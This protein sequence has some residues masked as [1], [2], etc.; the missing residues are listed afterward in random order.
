MKISWLVF[1]FI[2]AV[3]IEKSESG[4]G[5]FIFESL[6]SYSSFIDSLES[7]LVESISSG[8]SGLQSSGS[9]SSKS[10]DSSSDSSGS[11]SKPRDSSSSS[12]PR[13][14][15][16]VRSPN[17]SL[18][19][20][21]SSKSSSKPPS[22]SDKSKP[23]GSI[24]YRPSSTGQSRSLPK[25]GSISSRPSKSSSSWRSSRF[26]GS[27]TGSKP[28]GS[29][30][31][32]PASS[33]SSTDPCNQPLT[34]PNYGPRKGKLAN[35]VVQFQKSYSD[36]SNIK[37]SVNDALREKIGQAIDAIDSSDGASSLYGTKAF[38]QHLLNAKS[39][40]EH[41]EF[42]TG[43]SNINCK[44][45]V[46]KFHLVS[47]IGEL[48]AIESEDYNATV[49]VLESERSQIA[50]KNLGLDD[51]VAVLGAVI[52]TERKIYDEAELVIENIEN[53]LIGLETFKEEKCD[54]KSTTT[55]RPRK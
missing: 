33:S 54:T 20:K 14:S 47:H 51:V 46:E 55:G 21:P 26:S 42:G 43:P 49:R 9:E 27:R 10:S 11:S 39:K 45:V 23:S 7:S 12:R 29:S 34:R 40:V 5:S 17:Y 52:E 41:Y 6:P 53:L 18:K 25:Y 22:Q 30:Y 28:I 3:L 50:G 2:L 15:S 37:P 35:L 31:S 1:P 4:G 16:S 48:T 13:G 36:Y 38:L 24:K 32:K 19:S 44:N 8:S